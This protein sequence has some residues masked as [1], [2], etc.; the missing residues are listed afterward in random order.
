MKRVLLF[1]M[2]A[3]GK[4]EDVEFHFRRTQR[5]AD[6]AADESTT[7]RDENTFAVPKIAIHENLA[8]SQRQVFGNRG[9]RKDASPLEA[10]SRATLA[11]FL[12]TLSVSFNRS[13][14]AAMT[15]L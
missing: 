14:L 13:R 15:S 8:C 7:A 10:D 1:K 6:P 5:A 12:V 4:V 11:Y 3:R 9:K 2:L